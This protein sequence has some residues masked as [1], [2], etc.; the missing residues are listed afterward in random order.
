MTQPKLSK[1]LT[2]LWFFRLVSCYATSRCPKQLLSIPL[3]WLTHTHTFSIPNQTYVY[4]IIFIRAAISPEVFRQV[5]C[6]FSP[7]S[8]WLLPSSPNQ[9]VTIFLSACNFSQTK[10]SFFLDCLDDL[11]KNI[12]LWEIHIYFCVTSNIRQNSSTWCPEMATLIAPQLYL[13]TED[14]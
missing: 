10:L 9:C 2:I 5:Y 3:T 7:L 8:S 12:Y 6:Q 1:I 13:Y 4:T 11:F 14:P